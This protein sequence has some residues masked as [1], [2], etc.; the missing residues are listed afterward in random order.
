MTNYAKGVSEIV[1]AL[2]KKAK[3]VA[4]FSANPKSV[5]AHMHPNEQ[6][7]HVDEVLEQMVKNPDV[8]IN[9][10]EFLKQFGDRMQK[11]AYMKKQGTS[12]LNYSKED[13][14]LHETNYALEKQADDFLREK[15]PEF[16]E[17]LN[18]AMKNYDE[19]IES[20]SEY[21]KIPALL[22]QEFEQG[23]YIQPDNTKNLDKALLQY[24]L[25]YLINDPTTRPHITSIIKDA[26]KNPLNPN[27]YEQIYNK[28]ARLTALEEQIK[29]NL[30][31]KNKIFNNNL[32]EK[33]LNYH[34][35]KDPL[36]N[37]SEIEFPDTSLNKRYHNVAMPRGKYYFEGQYKPADY[38]H[39]IL[40][41]YINKGENKDALLDEFFKDIVKKNINDKVDKQFYLREW[42]RPAEKDRLYKQSFKD[43]YQTIKKYKDE[44]DKRRYELDMKN[45][46]YNNK[47]LNNMQLIEEY[48]DSLRPSSFEDFESKTLSPSSND[49]KILERIVHPENFR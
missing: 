3:M 30:E 10:D 14:L 21:S 4:D 43:K 23:F 37:A 19:N 22:E 28:P 46:P 15:D 34:L 44:L 32:E 18:N 20:V 27:N 25:D 11:E 9:T 33:P 41:N 2:S 35:S 42:L 39:N 26:N 6:S 7:L 38:Y 48:F 5:Y 8:D 49:K 16:F 24:Q 13:P 29:Y 17:E 36:E 40:W 45:K 47:K 31:N 1:K 12:L